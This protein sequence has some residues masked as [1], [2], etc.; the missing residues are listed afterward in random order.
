MRTKKAPVKS[1]DVG[2]K[3]NCAGTTDACVG[4]IETE[5]PAH[6]VRVADTVTVTLFNGTAFKPK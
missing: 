6:A 1:V 3:T 4:A 5:L 2:E